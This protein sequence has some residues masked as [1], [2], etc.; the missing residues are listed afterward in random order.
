MWRETVEQVA[1]KMVMD[2]YPGFA[3]DARA[4]RAPQASTKAPPADLGGLF[5]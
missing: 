3:G 2:P 1:N 5:E 4:Q